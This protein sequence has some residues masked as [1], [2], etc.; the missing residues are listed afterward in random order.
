MTGE[1]AANKDVQLEES[2]RRLYAHFGPQHWWPGKSAFEVILGAIL[3]QNTAWTNVE[4]AL[5]N[6]KRAGLLHVE[7]LH[8]A[9]EQRLAGLIR[10]SGYYH[11]KAKKLHAFTRFLFEKHHGRLSHLF[12]QETGALRDELLAVYGIG[13]ETADSIILY[14]AKQPIFVVDAYTRRIAARLGLARADA[15]Y[16]E[17]QQLFMDHLPRAESLFNE[18]HALLVALGKNYCKRAP[19]CSACPLREICQTGSRPSS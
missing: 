6:L 5:A 17:L 16:D 3:T 4:R 15:S 13:P 14:A 11:L 9:R 19:R 18:Y 7:Q 1:R 12:R 2:Y 10:P 8:K